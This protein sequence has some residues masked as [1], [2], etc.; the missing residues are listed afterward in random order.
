MGATALCAAA[1][2]P[3]EKSAP[4]VDGFVARWYHSATGETM[5]YRLFVPADYLAAKNYPVILWLHGAAGRGSDNLQQISGGNF[6]GTHV[7]T[8]PENQA[9]YHAFVIAPQ[10]DATKA[11][12]RPHAE[13]PALSIRLALEILDAIEKE[14][15]IDRNREYVAGQSMG[16]EGA[17]AAI[18]ARPGR[19][20]AAVPLCGYGFENMIVSGA[21]TPVWIWQGDKDEI[22]AVEGAR[23]WVAA[24]AKQEA[25]RNIQKFQAGATTCGEKRLPTRILFLGCFPSKEEIRPSNL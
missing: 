24:C 12:A 18:A 19:F 11:W 17:W 25:R 3:A 21:R 8:T 6:L 10:C 13:G 23:Q 4:P 9:K 16:G 1:Q 20:A 22:V 15:S 14:Y 2:K 7:W 5:P